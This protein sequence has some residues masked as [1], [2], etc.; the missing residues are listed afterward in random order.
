[1]RHNR[2]LYI[3]VTKYLSAR[4]TNDC[5]AC[6]KCVEACPRQVIS[7]VRFLWHRHIKISNPDRCVGCGKCVAACPRSILTLTKRNDA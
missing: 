6:W 1:M 5:A 7:K 3:Q 4:S 2:N